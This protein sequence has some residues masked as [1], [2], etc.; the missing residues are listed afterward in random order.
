MPP[1]MKAICPDCDYPLELVREDDIDTI[2]YC[3]ECNEN[4]EEDEVLWDED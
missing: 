3:K 4:W 2:Y 1:I